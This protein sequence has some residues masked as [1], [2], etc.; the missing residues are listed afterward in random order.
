MVAQELQE[1]PVSAARSSASSHQGETLI[2]S[3][4]YLTVTD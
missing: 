1:L 3:I 4:I 2:Y